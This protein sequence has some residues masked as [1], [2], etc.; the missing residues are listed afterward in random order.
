MART[1]REVDYERAHAYHNTAHELYEACVGQS[2]CLLYIGDNV[3]P[4]FAIDG[5]SIDA[6]IAPTAGKQGHVWL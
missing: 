5:V 4:G 1:A 2:A 6:R 3:W